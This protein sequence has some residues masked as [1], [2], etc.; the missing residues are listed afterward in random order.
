[1]ARAVDIRFGF[2]DS[3]GKK[4]S[5]VIHVP[6]G[7]TLADYDEFGEAMAQLLSNIS[8]GQ[9]TQG[10]ISYSVDL[11]G[12]GLKTSAVTLASIS[13]KLRLRFQTAATGFLAKMLIPAVR[14][15]LIGAGSDDADQGDTDV[16]ATISLFEDG[17]AVTGGTMTF[18]NSRDHDITSVIEAKE[19][20]LR[21]RKRS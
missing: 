13:R 17:I 2:I 5:T 11:S 16:A 4:A 7:F 1:M 6:T 18:T 20:F 21:R 15:T 9:I 3:K 14:E 8:Q 12:L 19:K 10:S